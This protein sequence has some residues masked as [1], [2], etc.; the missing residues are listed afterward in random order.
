ML[1]ESDREAQMAA[2][3]ARVTENDAAIREYERALGLANTDTREV[4]PAQRRAFRAGIAAGLERAAKVCAD[5]K[6]DAADSGMEADAAYNMA[7]DHC[8]AAIR[9]IK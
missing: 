5:E 6:V 2:V 8:A 1:T 9:A 4:T 3:E 7:C